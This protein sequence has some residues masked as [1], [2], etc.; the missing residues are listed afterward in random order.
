MIVAGIAVVISAVLLGISMIFPGRRH[1]AKYCRGVKRYFRFFAWVL[2]FVF[3]I[4]TLN[5]TMIYHGSTFSEK[6]FGEE[7][8]QQDVTLQ[9]RTEELLRIYNDI[10]SHCNALSME[11]ERD[12]SGAVVYSGGLD[13]KGNA[14]D[15]AGKAIGAMQNLGKS[16]AQLDGYYPRPKAMFFSDFMCQMYM[17]GYYFPFSM[18]ANYNDVMSIM[19]KP[20]TMCHELAHIRG[21]IYEDE[22][23]FI[24]FLACVESDDAA[25]QYSG[26]LSVLNY[27]ANDLY[28][29]RLADPESYAAAREATAGIAAGAG[30]QY[31]RHRG[32]MGEDQRESGSGHGDRGQCHRYS[33]GCFA[34][35]EW[36]VGRHDQLQPGSGA[37]VTMVRPTR[38]VLT[39]T[40]VGDRGIIAKI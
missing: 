16:Y 15:M 19:K 38:G 23:N 40:F 33:D 32:G 39:E 14:V 29:T 22:A 24:A 28:K 2:L 12:D 20:A 11:I 25:F 36:S 7:E 8:G 35:A 1:S 31:L 17:C 18:E 26:Y 27:V 34:E 6:Y 9:E 30:G 3:A 5:C 21:Y 10:V 4:M 13:S 37:V